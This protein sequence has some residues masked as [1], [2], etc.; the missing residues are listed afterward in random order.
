MTFYETTKNAFAAAAAAAVVSQFAVAPRPSMPCLLQ[1]S[2][3]FKNELL[4]IQVD[5]K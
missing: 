2:Y 3:L 4:A 5:M 1:F